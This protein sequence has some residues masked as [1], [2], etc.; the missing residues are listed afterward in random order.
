MNNTKKID[1]TCEYA[2]FMLKEIF[3]QGEV[4][5]RI[6][7]EHI[8]IKQKQVVFKD[9]IGKAKK[10]KKLNRIIIVGCGTSYHA[11][12]IGKYM[13][14]EYARIITEVE[15]ADEFIS[16]KFNIDN[17]TLIITISQSGRTADIIKA[18]RL[19]KKEKAQILSLT[20]YPGSPL[21]KM[22]D[23]TVYNQAGEEKA[24]AATKTFT[25]QIILLALLVLYLGKTMHTITSINRK[26]IIREIIKLPENIEKILK[27]NL[28]FQII[29]NKY[30]KL[31]NLLVLGK[32]YHYPLSLEAALKFKE[33]TYM[34]VEG[35]SAGEFLHGPLAIADKSRPCLLFVPVDNSY[36][37][38]K[39]LVRKIDKLK[40]KQ[41][42]VTTQG[43]RQ[44]S[45]LADSIIYIPKTINL[46]IPVLSI[47]PIQ[48]L[49]YHIAALKG[50][51]PD[52]PR[53]L[54]KFVG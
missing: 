15:F 42:I 9:L 28:Q 25:S 24:M 37:A 14:A 21:D 11:A 51:N 17:K 53:N 16:R 44:L 50:I 26:K 49:V 43:N 40:I 35:F 7:D 29:A 41:I 31:E 6:V 39:L 30:Y 22:D 3:E 27:Q 33:T 48:L 13:L 23:L 18:V 36:K 47:I 34:H 52:K 12:L 4:I 19:A 38:M 20:N 1:K 54:K 8:K 5:R 45:K 2:H 10:I 32:N 46:L